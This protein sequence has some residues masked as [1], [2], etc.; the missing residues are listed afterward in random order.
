MAYSTNRLKAMSAGSGKAPS[1]FTYRTPDSIVDLTTAGYFKEAVAIFEV[2]DLIFANVNDNADVAFLV[3]AESTP[4]D[5]GNHLVNFSTTSSFV[6]DIRATDVAGYQSDNFGGNLG[7]GGAV[8][9]YFT[10]RNNTDVTATILAPDYFLEAGLFLEVGDMVQVVAND[11]AFLMRVL[12]TGTTGV[13]T[14]EV[15]F[16]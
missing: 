8:F 5:G 15:V 11:G 10:Y 12:T 6:G 4:V 9:N 1:I 14:E 7:A 2:G 3:C 16:V 13:T